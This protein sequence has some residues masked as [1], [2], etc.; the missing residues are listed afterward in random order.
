MRSDSGLHGIPPASL[1]RPDHVTDQ[2]TE[3]PNITQA[4]RSSWGKSQG[5]KPEVTLLWVSV[6]FQAGCQVVP[7]R[8]PIVA[9]DD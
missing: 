6:P 3:N 4:V 9:S 8:F 7:S 5:D 2:E 1:L